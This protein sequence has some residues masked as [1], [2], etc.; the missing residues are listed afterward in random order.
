MRI[1][2]STFVPIISIVGDQSLKTKKQKE[3][4]ELRKYFRF[5]EKFVLLAEIVPCK[6][7][8][9]FVD[10]EHHAIGF[11]FH[12]DKKEGQVPLSIN[13]K[14]NHRS[15]SARILDQIEWAKDIGFKHI[16]DRRFF[17]YRLHE[18][19]GDIWVIELDNPHYFW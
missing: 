1:R 10:N 12:R 17:P 5:N 2:K 18:D 16:R 8:S 14:L 11:R 3:K 4:K 15:C 6:S 9:F 13:S 19:D 7:V